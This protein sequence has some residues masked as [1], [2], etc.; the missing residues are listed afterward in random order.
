VKA[1]A[2][3][4]YPDNRI[5]DALEAAAKDPVNKTVMFHAGTYRPPVRDRRSSGSMRDTT[6]SRWKPSAT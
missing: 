6:A 5:Q 3:H 4:V 2:Y 1:R